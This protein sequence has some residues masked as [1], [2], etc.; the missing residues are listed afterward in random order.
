MLIKAFFVPNVLNLFIN[1]TFHFLEK[2][3]V[4]QVFM[5]ITCVS[6]GL[7]GIL[8][9]YALAVLRKILFRILAFLFL[10][11]GTDGFLLLSS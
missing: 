2:F 11:T 4:V 6:C 10:A 1:F 3:V 7:C 5:I 9:F 8:L